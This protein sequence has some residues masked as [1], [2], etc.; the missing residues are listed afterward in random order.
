MIP[1]ANA[2]V[3]ALNAHVGAVHIISGTKMNSLFHELSTVKGI[4]T[5]FVREGE[6][7]GLLRYLSK[8][9]E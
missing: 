2:C 9:S 4:G 5:K 6:D 3:E 7:V 8:L 1:K